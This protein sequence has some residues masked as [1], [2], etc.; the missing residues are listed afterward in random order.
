MTLVSLGLCKS[1]RL[2]RPNHTDTER[3]PPDLHYGRPGG[4]QRSGMG[5]AGSARD[6]HPFRFCVHSELL[7]GSCPVCVPEAEGHQ[8]RQHRGQ[9]EG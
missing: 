1:H 3:A 6:Q 8:E 5:K 9:D 7:G 4:V 2:R